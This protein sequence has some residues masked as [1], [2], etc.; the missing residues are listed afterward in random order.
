M[1]K[2]ASYTLGSL[3][4]ENQMTLTVSPDPIIDILNKVILFKSSSQFP[5]MFKTMS[6]RKTKNFLVFPEF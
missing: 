2:I 6:K 4:I 3:D 5:F 1:K